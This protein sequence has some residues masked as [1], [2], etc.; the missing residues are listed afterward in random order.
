MQVAKLTAG[1]GTADDYFGCCVSISGDTAIVGAYG[2][3]DR[4]SDSGSAYIFEDTGS[5]WTQVA[6]LTAGDGAASDYFG[7][8]VSISGD[9]AIVGA[10]CDDDRG[11]DSGSAYVFQDTGSGWTQVAKLTAGDGAAGDCF[12]CCVSISGGTAIVGPCDD[13]D[14]GGDS[15][16]AYVFE[17]TGSGWTQ[18]AK[19]TAGDGAADDYFGCSVSISGDDGDR[20]GYGD[21]DHGADSGSAYVFEDTG[22][23]WIQVAKLT[24]DDGA[25]TRLLRLLASR[26]AAT[27][28]IVGAYDDDDRGADSGSAY[29]FED[30]GSGWTQ[31]AKLTAGDGA[32][33]DRFG[34]GRRS[35]ATPP[36]AAATATTTSAAIP[37]RPTSSMIAWPDR[38]HRRAGRRPG[39]ERRRRRERHVHVLRAGLRR[40]RRRD[41][42]RSERRLGD[43]GR[44]HGL[45]DR[46]IGSPS[47]ARR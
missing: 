40:R 36:S 39:D 18:V 46:R 19:L 12:G 16:S 47:F 11:S 20:R 25:A 22:S 6:K 23:G 8:S 45:G 42:A 29:V 32:A 30:T 4:G 5:G 37:A 2:D 38:R 27:R 9:T 26:S 44:R 1:D 14:R 31:V 15:G 7:Y 13:D 3:D 41:R 24:A 34:L 43:A 35:A 28:A 17:N 21:D 33:D 10:Y